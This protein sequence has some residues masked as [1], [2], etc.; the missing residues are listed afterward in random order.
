MRK[1]RRKDGREVVI[2]SWRDVTAIAKKLAH[3]IGESGFQPEVI[4]SVLRGGAI[5]GVLLSHHLD[6]QSVTTLT[7]RTTT[8]EKAYAERR[9]PRPNGLGIER[10]VAKK[11]VLLVDDVANTGRT[12]NAAKNLLQK[13]GC[14]DLRVAILIRDT[15]GGLFYPA[16]YVGKELPMWV[17]FPWE[18]H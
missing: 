3:Q 9:E 13:S 12:L 5:P 7:I 17:Q 2:L 16:D 1:I 14:R 4:V 15:W 10:H 11:R 6:I 18:K 8:S